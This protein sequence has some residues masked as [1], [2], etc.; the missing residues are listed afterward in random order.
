MDFQVGT[1]K[2]DLRSLLTGYTS[3]Q[4]PLSAGSANP[5]FS[6]ANPTFTAS[7]TTPR[8]GF[9]VIYNGAA[10]VGDAKLDFAVDASVTGIS[11]AQNSGYFGTFV[12]AGNVSTG[13]VGVLGDS[14]AFATNDALARI[15]FTLAAGTTGYI[16]ALEA[17]TST[18]AGSNTNPALP[19]DLKVGTVPVTAGK[20]IAVLDTGSTVATPGDNELHYRV[21]HPTQTINV[22]GSTL[23]V[24]QIDIRYDTNA[25]VGTTT[26]SETLSML[27]V[28]T[29]QSPLQ[30]SFND[31][32]LV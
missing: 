13:V 26:A 21:S 5:V 20:L 1:D 7:A 12:G 25:A 11:V 32:Y 17:G 3:V 10:S 23:N 27:F 16:L 4:A 6:Y 18:Y 24:A 28:E 29:T 14:P 9:D 31:F 2:I 15:T 22:N 19:A 8:V 30:L